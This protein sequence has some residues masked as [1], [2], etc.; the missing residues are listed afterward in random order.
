MFLASVATYGNEFKKKK[1]QKRTS[2]NNK[3]L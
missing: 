1:L 2:I 3:Y